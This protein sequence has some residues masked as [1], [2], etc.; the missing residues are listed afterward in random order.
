MAD[1]IKNTD[2]QGHLIQ[3]RSEKNKLALVADTVSPTSFMNEKTANLLVSTVKLAAKIKL[4]DNHEANRMV[5]YNGYKIPSFGQLIA[6]IESRGWTMQTTSSIEVDDRRANILGRNLLPQIGLQLHQER[7]PVRMS[8]IHFNNIDSSDAQIV[9]WVRTTYPGICTR[10]RR[11]KK[12]H[13][14]YKLLKRRKRIPIHIQEKVENEVRSLI[15]QSHIVRVEKCSD[16][17]FISPIAITVKKNQSKKLAMD[18]KQ[19]NKSIHKNKYQMPNFVVLLDNKAQSAQE[20]TN[21]LGSTCFSTIDLR[22]ASSQIP[23]DDTTRTQCNFSISGGNATGTYQF[24]TGFYGLIDTPAEFQKAID[25]RLN[26]KKDKSAFLDDILMISHGTKEQ[27][28]E[29][30]TRVLINL[31]AEKMAISVDKCKFGCKQV[32]WLG[33]V[34]NEYGTTPMQEKTDANINLKHS[35]TFE[36]LKSFMGSI[37]HLNKFIPNLA[38]FCTRLQPLLS[39]SNKFNFACKGIMK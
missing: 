36:E 12:P 11:S 23:L 21:K 2:L 15:D 14:S 34:I 6:P 31:D 10:I 27:H 9:D 22:Y 32:E 20:G 13:G 25:L 1:I 24:Q 17:Q 4:G 38:Q 16:Q 29:K 19:I 35:K 37:H 33:F 8:T 5:C 30:L 3:V 28:I 26:S 18:S 39:T 7:K